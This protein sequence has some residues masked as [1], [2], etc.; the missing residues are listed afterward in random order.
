MILSWQQHKLGCKVS[1]G[2]LLGK[3]VGANCP[4]VL[5]GE[6]VEEECPSG[7]IRIAMQDYKSLCVVAMI[8]ATLVNTQICKE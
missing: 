8:S 3:Y 5:S 2:E 1:K 7:T 4:E 6:N